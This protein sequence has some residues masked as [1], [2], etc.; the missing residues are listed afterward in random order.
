MLCLASFQRPSA[1]NPLRVHTASALAGF[2][3]GRYQTFTG[4]FQRA[5]KEK[6]GL[7]QALG[8]RD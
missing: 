4:G 8:F 5:R 3:E 2:D 7:F 1:R 6:M